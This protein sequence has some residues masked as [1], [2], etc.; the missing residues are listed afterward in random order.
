MSSVRTKLDSYKLLPK[1]IRYL[2]SYLNLFLCSVL[3]KPKIYGRKNIPQN[4]PYIVAINHFHI[5]DPALVAYAIRKPISF[6]AAS[7]QDIDWQV[8]IAGKLYGFIPTNRQKLAPSTIKKAIQ[9]LQ[10]GDILGIFPEATTGPVLRRPKKGV[11]YLSL[12]SGCKI[13]PMGIVGL[14]EDIWSQWFKGVR[15]Q[16]AVK[17]GKP[18]SISS[19]LPKDRSERQ[20]K[21]SDI[22]D[23]IM[24]KIATLLPN[25][26]RGEYINDN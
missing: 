15:P 24:H 18:F 22:G 7:D 4:G 23:D 11:T 5:F 26:Y 19:S 21:L 20:N 2:S 1:W 3:L 8:L 10:K 14:E 12:K 16:V 13:L 9:A 6:L 17:I 25:K